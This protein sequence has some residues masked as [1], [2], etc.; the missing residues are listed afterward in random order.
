MKKW[1][2]KEIDFLKKNY[3][4]L[5]YQKISE[6]LKRSTGSIYWKCFELDL[7]KER[8]NGENRL[9]KQ[10]VIKML[11][12]HKNKLG[13]SPSLRETP[14]PL[15]SA[16][17]RHFGNL[18]KAKKAAGMEIREY[19]K[20]LPKKAHQP[21]KELAYIIGILLGDGSFRYQKSKERTSYVIIYATKDKELMEYFSNKF[22]KWSNSKPN[23][24][25]I[26]GGIKKFPGGNISKYQE[27]YNT[28]IG[29]R[30]AWLFLKQFKNSP[31]YCLKFFSKKEYNWL[32]KGLWDAE[33]CIRISNKNI[34]TD[35]SNSDEKLLNLYK[36]LLKEFDIRYQI[37]RL[38]SGGTNITI[39][40]KLSN[41]KFLKTI[42]GITIERKNTPKIK[43][44]IANMSKEFKNTDL[45]TNFG[46]QVYH[47]TKLIPCGHVSTYREIAHA[48][49][50]KAYRAVGTALNKN[51]N[52]P[53]VPC[54]RVINTN[55]NVGGFASGTKNKIKLLKKEGIEIKNNKIDLK[56]YLWK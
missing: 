8:W 12:E 27:T 35:F 15:R 17:Q 36:E 28:Q 52:A 50:S 39:S 24:S 33:G 1:D 56:E 20:Q 31:E 14:I 3:N 23:I 49:N 30:D 47:V 48:L 2:K 45:S 43:Q 11:L 53:T 41:F 32:I 10:K 19:A 5:P 18:N 44:L 40:D 7:K 55:G 22:K 38:K 9:N 29:F 42:K 37:N 16:C 4:K 26:K 46:E 54:H 34:R 21:S 6:K 25:I 13:K 51:P